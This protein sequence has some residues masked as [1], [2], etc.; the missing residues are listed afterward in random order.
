MKTFLT[1][2][3]LHRRTEIV[4][5][6]TRSVSVSASS[7]LQI[8]GDVIDLMC[9]ICMMAVRQPLHYNKQVLREWEVVLTKAL[10]SR[11]HL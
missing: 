6:S 8:H 3:F 9:M 10:R 2:L 4:K 1:G 11:N 5:F 7:G